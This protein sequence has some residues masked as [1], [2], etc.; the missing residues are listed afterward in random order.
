MAGTAQRQRFSPI[1]STFVLLAVAIVGAGSLSFYRFSTAPP[2]NVFTFGEA[3]FHPGASRLPPPADAPGWAGVTLPHRWRN[4]APRARQGWYALDLQVKVPPNRLWGLYVPRVRSNVTA[5][6]NGE[7]IGRGGRQRS[8]VARNDNRPLYFS[9]PNGAL[10]AG[11]NRIDMRVKASVGSEGLLGA[12]HLGPDELLR[13]YFQRYFRL[14]VNV[15]EITTASLLLIAVLML[16]L[17]CIR[18][19]DSLALWFALTAIAWAVHNLNLLV[20]EIPMSAYTWECIRYLSV[21]WFVVLLVTSMHRLLGVRHRRAETAM[22]VGALI[23]SL[24]LCALAGSDDFFAFAKRVWL[25]ASVLLGIY[26]AVRVPFAWW[27]SRD[28]EYFVAMFAGLP[29]L[30]T[31]AFDWLQV[32]GL[33]SGQ[34]G[35]LMQYS[36]VPMLL[37]FV[38]I[39]LMRY[40]RALNASEEMNRTLELRI[41]EK[42]RQLEANYARLRHLER[43]RVLSEERER[44]M[45]DMHDGVGGHLVSALSMTEQQPFQPGA[46]REILQNALMDL[47]LMIDS[48][49]QTEGHLASVLGV[50]RE[51]LQPALEKSGI[52]VNWR[53]GDLPPIRTLGASQVLHIT[54][55][56]QEAIT[57]VLKHS[58]AGTLTVAASHDPEQVV[59]EVTDDGKG[60]PDAP[61][62]GHGLRNM[63]HRARQAGIGL[64]IGKAQPGTR[65]RISVPLAD[66][67]PAR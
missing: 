17:W 49:D 40:A 13:P 51:R 21:G 57:N 58:G 15:V 9:I 53:I 39:L 41:D 5:Y 44:I 50:L 3:L 32:N 30:V 45:R 35:A 66:G 23:G 48:M 52:T 36:A 18:R 63:R 28:T 10:R 4:T 67:M 59:I 7:V 11:H 27:K 29:V 43:A 38:V 22:Y 56:L 12:V 34:H 31:G 64:D 47:R 8:P 25:T 26:P 62:P 65:I 20:V 16:G 37:G 1:A 46:F 54:R 14:R 6:I 33:A 19:R 2:S 60:I 24:V 42:G 61:S 55:I